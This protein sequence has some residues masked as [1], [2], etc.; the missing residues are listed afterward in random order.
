MKEKK[1]NFPMVLHLILMVTLGILN[2][3]ALISYF[4]GTAAPKLLDVLLHIFNVLALASGLIYLLKG[5]SK[6]AAI[7][8]KVFMLLTAV[9]SVILSTAFITDFGFN[10]G[11]ALLFVEI[12][13]LLILTFAKDLGKR[14]TWI[15]FG[16]LLVLTLLYGIL[17]A[18]KYFNYRFFVILT[19]I[20]SKLVLIGTVGFAIRGKY[21]DKDARGTK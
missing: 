5:Y 1:F 6:S 14:N 3:I 16:A 13:I 19:T 21:A 11:S 8:Y 20:F 4:T 17:F 9:S 12:A 2:V 15:F 10:V 18:P 7:Y